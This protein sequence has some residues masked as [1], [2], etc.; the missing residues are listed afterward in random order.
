MVLRSPIIK[1]VYKTENFVADYNEV[2]SGN[3]DGFTML[4]RPQ[5]FFSIIYYARYNQDIYSGDCA[6]PCIFTTFICR[7]H[8]KIY[9]PL[10]MY[11]ETN[12]LSYK[13]IFLC[14]SGYDSCGWC[15]FPIKKKH[16][17]KSLRIHVETCLLQQKFVRSKK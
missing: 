14:E 2:R 5:L 15:T 3:R 6:P 4:P 12:V 8:I 13:C 11:I 1:N 17:L 9:I 10:Y 16:I 7:I